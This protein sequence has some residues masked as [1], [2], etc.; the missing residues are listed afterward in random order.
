MTGLDKIIQR[1]LGD[2]K[3]EARKILESA[4]EDCQRMAEEYAAEAEATKEQI[5]TAAEE[6]CEALITAAK[7]KAATTRRN[8]LQG[9]RAAMI[10]KA[11]AMAERKIKDTDFGKYRELLTALLTCALLDA[12]KTADN[13][14]ALGDEVSEFD[15]YEVLLNEKDKE[16]F[17]E[18]IVEDA[19][20]AV[21]RH[22]GWE[23]AEK[24]RLSNE[25]AKIDSGLI[26]RYGDVS[27]NCSLSL[28]LAELRREME[29]QIMTL[30]FAD[31]QKN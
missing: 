11:F 28:L 31:E 22:I 17:G 2:A 4:S 13:A 25:A 30:L 6:E 10:D 16:A 12:A 26:L 18:D 19:R 1:I 15:G 7:T 5:A 29:Q 8:A 20:R 21:T 24:L 9:A 14:A 3:D 23:R 27:C